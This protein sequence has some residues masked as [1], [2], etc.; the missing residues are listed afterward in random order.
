[1][2]S[3]IILGSF[4]S[5][6]GALVL[7]GTPK[8]LLVDKEESRIIALEKEITKLKEKSIEHEKLLKKLIEDNKNLK[9]NNDK[10]IEML[11]GGDECSSLEIKN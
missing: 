5:I 11:E 1:M 10:I 6:V 2:S 9:Y 3:K 4:L 7:L 8:V